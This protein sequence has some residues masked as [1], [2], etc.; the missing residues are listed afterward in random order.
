MRRKQFNLLQIINVLIRLNHSYE[1][2]E[3]RKR[4]SSEGRAAIA[5]AGTER[6][7]LMLE[8]VHSSL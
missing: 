7:V 6:R 1:W 2:T 3:D 4:V 8:R 5:G